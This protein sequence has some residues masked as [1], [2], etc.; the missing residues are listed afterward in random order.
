MEGYA[1]TSMQSKLLDGFGFAVKSVGNTIAKIP[2]ISKGPVDEA[3][4]SAG[5]K[6]GK[7]GEKRH[8]K[9]MTSFDSNG[10]ASIQLFADNIEE[11]NR[12]SN[13]PVELLFDLD[14]VYICA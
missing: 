5:E 12:L 1:K 3:L 13:Q 11:I 10:D 9:F 8:M 4:I 14:M 7:Y 6:V 2:I